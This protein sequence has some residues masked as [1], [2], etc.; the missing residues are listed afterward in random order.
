MDCTLIWRW[1]T[2]A[3]AEIRTRDLEIVSPA[4]FQAAEGAQVQG[5]GLI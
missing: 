1:Y 5:P 2:V 3:V 4:L